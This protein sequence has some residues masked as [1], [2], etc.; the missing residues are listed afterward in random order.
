MCWKSLITRP[1]S[2]E[3][4]VLETIAMWDQLAWPC[5]ASVFARGQRKAQALSITQT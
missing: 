5:Q 1:K 3:A 4:P 2:Q